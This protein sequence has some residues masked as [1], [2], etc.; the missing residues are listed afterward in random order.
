MV[1]LPDPPKRETNPVVWAVPSRVTAEFP[2][3]ESAW[4]LVMLTKSASERVAS[5]A[6]ARVFVPPAASMVSPLKGGTPP[7]ELTITMSSEA[8]PRMEVARVW[9]TPCVRVL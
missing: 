4:K 1:L 2:L 7:P 3:S 9:L 5:T 6:T 8:P